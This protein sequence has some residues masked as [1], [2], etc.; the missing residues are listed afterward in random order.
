MMNILN[1]VLHIMKGGIK[2]GSGEACNNKKEKRPEYL[3]DS[4]ATILR[5]R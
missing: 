4:G 3:I 5:S 2:E 1:R